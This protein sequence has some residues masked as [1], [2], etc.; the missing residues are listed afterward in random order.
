MTTIYQ[1]ME[2]QWRMRVMVADD[3][4]LFREGLARLL[5][6]RGF[7]VMGQAGD[8][9]W[10]ASLVRKDPPDVVVVDIRMPP[11]YT[12]EGLTVARELR[13]EHPGLGVLILSQY[14]ETHYAAQLF[15]EVESCG[16]GGAGYLLKDR[17]TRLGDLESGV[18]R[19]GAGGL[20]LDPSVVDRLLRRRRTRDPLGELTD[21]EREVL[22]L[23]AEGRTNTA[24]AKAMSVT[25]KTIEAHVRNIFDRLDLA[26]TEDDNR[27][28]LAVLAYLR[29]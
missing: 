22:G 5:T 7:D 25:V 6:E 27:R 19:V 13:A 8:A 21:R 29:R 11:T 28:V 2:G 18:R 9:A 3:S 15:E 10:L 24:I 1:L 17:V 20:V 16:G 12:A 14:V 26:L 4:L 23:M